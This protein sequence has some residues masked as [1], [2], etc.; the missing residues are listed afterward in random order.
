MTGH[1]GFLQ[2]FTHGF[3]GYRFRSDGLYF[4]PS[5]PPQLSS[6]YTVKGMKYRG[7]TLDVTV[8]EMDTII[9]NRENGKEVNITIGSRNSK[10]GNYTLSSGDKL[11]IPTTRLDLLEPSFQGNQV[12]CK[13][14]TE[15]TS[16]STWVPGQF[17]VAAV[18]G[19][20]AT[21]FQPTTTDPVS[22]TVDLGSSK[23]IKSINL[24][25]GKNPPTLISLLMGSNVESLSETLMRQEVNISNP[26]DLIQANSVQVSVGNTT[27]LEV[28]SGTMSRFIQVVIEGASIENKFNHGATIAEI[29][30]I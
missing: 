30:V 11:K 14:S 13:S 18:D 23:S 2:T 16:N 4:D 9:S 5:L 21:L 24:N 27:S 3:T 15:I 12:Q 28:V 10:A 7:A 29:N 1:G 8:G 25:F 22:L 26:Y 19:S 6:G 20:N 17:P